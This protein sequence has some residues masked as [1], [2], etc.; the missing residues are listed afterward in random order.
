MNVVFLALKIAYTVLT[1]SL[2]GSILWP[3]FG[4]SEFPALLVLRFG[5]L[6]SKIGVKHKQCDTVT[7]DLITAKATK[8]LMGR[9][10]YSTETPDKGND[11]HPGRAEQDQNSAQF[12]TYDCLF[13]E[14]SFN[15]FG[16]WFITGN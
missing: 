6:L 16:P 9:G 13:L 3:S 5:P 8:W 12:K 15:I 10:V 1:F 7:V 4:T 14:F 11:S 2:K